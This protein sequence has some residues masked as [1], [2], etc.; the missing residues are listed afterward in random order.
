MIDV[1]AAFAPTL[2]SSYKVVV[3]THSPAPDAYCGKGWFSGLILQNE[4]I[5]GRPG[6][7]NSVGCWSLGADSRLLTFR[8]FS[9]EAGRVVE[10]K[11]KAEDT[12]PMKMREDLPLLYD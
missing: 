12:R 6:L 7:S 2:D 10:F 5:A 8:Y 9:L 1:L 4:R 3:M 11:I